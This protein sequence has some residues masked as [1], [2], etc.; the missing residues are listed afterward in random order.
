MSEKIIREV[1]GLPVNSERARNLLANCLEY[2]QIDNVACTCDIFSRYA[3]KQNHHGSINNERPYF[4]IK[5]S[6][7]RFRLTEEGKK[8][9]GL[10]DIDS[11]A[12]PDNDDFWPN[13]N[14]HHELTD[15]EIQALV[16]EGL[17]DAGVPFVLPD[18]LKNNDFEEM[19]I[20]D[21]VTM[22]IVYPRD[23]NEIPVIIVETNA[24]S[25]ISID[26]DSCPYNL[27]NE[28]KEEFKRMRGEP[29][30]DGVEYVDEDT[31]ENVVDEQTTYIE[32]DVEEEVQEEEQPED[33][34]DDLPEEIRRQSKKIWEDTTEK[35]ATRESEIK[36][37]SE[38]ELPID[39]PEEEISSVVEKGRNEMS[40]DMKDVVRKAQK[41]IPEDDIYADES[42]FDPYDGSEA[43]Y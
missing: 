22:F 11:V 36:E 21:G 5:G 31:F 3:E 23:E 27:V 15:D 16:P 10:S 35:M 25:D 39:E 4:E 28:I 30:Q 43:D 2:K 20:P 12:M 7:K 18:L 1:C 9:V 8:A 6:A 24:L 40:S 13:I 19:P 17:F 42:D 29:S 37:A 38:A 34:Q 33:E 41:E 32:P 14:Y 26:K